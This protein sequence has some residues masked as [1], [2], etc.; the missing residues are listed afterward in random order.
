MA[1]LVSA[2]HER[3]LH[4][5]GDLAE[6]LCRILHLEADQDLAAITTLNADLVGE[7]ALSVTR[8]CSREGR[9]CFHI[10]KISADRKTTNKGSFEEAGKESLHPRE[11]RSSLPR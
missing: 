10:G 3:V 7:A 8:S 9:S 4:G 5:C 6:I 2:D 1:V 11:I